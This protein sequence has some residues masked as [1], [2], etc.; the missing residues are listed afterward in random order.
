MC[1]LFASQS[2]ST[3]E[4]HTRSVRIGG[5]STSL[6][7]EA[8]Y[9]D[10]LEELAAHQGMSLGKFITRL[11]DEVLEMH[12]E[13]QNFASLLRCSCLLYVADLRPKAAPPEAVR[14]LHLVAAE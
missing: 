2:P 4:S 13:V 9:W 14:D 1:H 8:A 10:I 11:H 3:Y 7:L 12:G 6:R 5:H